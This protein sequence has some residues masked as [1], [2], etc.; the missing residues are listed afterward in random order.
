MKVGNMDSLFSLVSFALGS[1]SHKEGT[2]DFSF[3]VLNIQGYSASSTIKVCD[4]QT[5]NRKD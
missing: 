5:L 4:G 3:Q 1:A 2:S